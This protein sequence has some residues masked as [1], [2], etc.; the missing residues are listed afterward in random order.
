MAIKVNLHGSL[1]LQHCINEKPNHESDLFSWNP[2]PSLVIHNLLSLLVSRH[3][4][5]LDAFDSLNLNKLKLIIAMPKKVDV[6]EATSD[7][8]AVSLDDSILI[9]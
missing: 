9:A 6:T 8:L 4:A 7:L 2:W 1:T 3:Q 5:H